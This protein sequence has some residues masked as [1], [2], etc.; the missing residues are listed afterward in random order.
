MNGRGS[1]KG[2]LSGQGPNWVEPASPIEAIAQE[3]EL[4][5]NESVMPINQPNET[6][7]THETAKDNSGQ[8]EKNESKVIQGKIQRLGD[9]VDT[10]AVRYPSSINNCLQQA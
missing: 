1:L 9:F 5:S 8:E 6:K 4:N 7:D 3:G 2:T 10:D